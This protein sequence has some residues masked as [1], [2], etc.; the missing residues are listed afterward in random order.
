MQRER[1]ELET[2]AITIEIA[3]SGCVDYL[4]FAKIDISRLESDVKSWKRT[5]GESNRKIERNERNIGGLIVILTLGPLNRASPV[6][7]I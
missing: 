3:A 4:I 5:L 2:G 1:N 7:I 6:W